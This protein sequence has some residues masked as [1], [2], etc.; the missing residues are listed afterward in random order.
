MKTIQV[1]IPEKLVNE[2]EEYVKE[3]WFNN[4]GELMREALREFIRHHRPMLMEKYME[5]DIEWA[6]KVKRTLDS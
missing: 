4:E 1:D 5:E 6:L 2:I 3:G